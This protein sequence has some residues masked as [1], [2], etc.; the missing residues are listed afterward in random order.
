M[1]V[2]L[3]TIAV[4]AAGA[5]GAEPTAHEWPMVAGGSA[6]TGR[7]EDPRV[8]PP[9]RLRWAVKTHGCI[10]ATLAVA[11]GRVFAV[12]QQ[13]P[14]LALDADTGR[15]LW[16][17]EVGGGTRSVS[18]DGR[19]VFYDRHGL[20]ALDAATGK[21][22]WRDPSRCV[23]AWRYSPAFAEGV[24]YWGRRGEDGTYAS[25]LRC[26]DGAEIWRRR[27]GG[28]RTS[29]CAPSLAAGRVLLTTRNPDAAVALD[30][31]TGKQL[32]RTEGLWAM[33]GVSSDG[34]RAYV[35]ENRGGLTALDLATGEKKWHWG[36]STA[37]K[38]FYTREG[39]TNNPPTVAFG[40]LFVKAYYGFFTVL[41]PKDG[42]VDWTFDDGA[43]TGCAMPSAAGGHLYFA[44]GN[45]APRTGGGRSIYAID[46]NTRK[47][48]WRY[49]T[50]GRVCA[51][52][53]IAYG[54]LYVGGNDGRVYCFEPAAGDAGPP[55]PQV[56]PAAPAAP[57]RRLARRFT[58]TPGS[59]DT[60]PGKPAGRDEW[61]MY[62]GCPARCGRQVKIALPIRPAWRFDTG[63]PVRSSPVIA[64]GRV[65]VGS[66]SGRLFAL[67]LSTGRPTW[68]AALGA[69]VRCAPA[70]AGGLVVCG[71]DDGVLRALDAAGGTERWRFRTGGAVRAAPAV[72]GDRVVF[73]S[74]DQHCY[75][76]RLRDGAELWR[77]KTDHEV[78]AAPAVANG[79]V[80]VGTWGWR[81]HALDLGTGKPLAGFQPSR[82]YRST[83]CGRVEGVAVYRGMVVTVN[84]QDEAYGRAYALDANTGEVLLRTGSGNGFAFGAPAFDG[85][86]MFVPNAWKGV[87]ICDLQ[88]RRYLGDRHQSPSRTAQTP[89]VAAELMILATRKGTVEV[90]DVFGGDAEQPAAPRWRWA[91]PGGRQFATAP[92][93]AAGLFVLGNDDG[94]VY[95]FRH[96]AGATP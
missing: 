75:C 64:A 79:T 17:H 53:A 91:A 81:L 35:A 27:I 66:D 36:G 89:L 38:P 77:Y 40:R 87:G 46:P 18:S 93:A 48:V 50:G 86:W 37:R 9:L 1:I 2:L 14:L 84:C 61:P 10:K 60:A 55:S 34:T 78:H 88:G 33:R 11:G 12:V 30:A 43:G 49:R 13:G 25:A 26:A 7:S 42:T 59:A 41:R 31:G 63:G 68:T 94:H 3:A 62:G 47:A 90:R 19:R 80:F 95:A 67:D 32:W 65:H 76:L 96:T 28:P 23:D 16:R 70:V 69:P 4:L 57:L 71:A 20:H 58:G 15:V 85:R 8:R 92:A 39:T 73:G 72:V 29:L 52:P 54:R 83:D 51:M 6:W 21:V 74:L 82:R 45:Y 44:T 24:L 22:L 56:P 5:A